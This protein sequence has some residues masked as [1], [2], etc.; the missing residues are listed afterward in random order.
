MTTE[1]PHPST[2]VAFTVALGLIENEP[3][4]RTHAVESWLRIYK[5]EP[6]A[7]FHAIA[8]DHYATLVDV[9]GIEIRL[10]V[11]NDRRPWLQL[12]GES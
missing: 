5:E 1:H 8:G 9:N 10:I 12:V 3:Y 11:V 4:T 6:D 7:P 2:R